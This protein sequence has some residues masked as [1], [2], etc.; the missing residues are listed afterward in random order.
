MEQSMLQLMEALAKTGKYCRN[1]TSDLH[2]N[3]I[4][5]ISRHGKKC[6]RWIDKRYPNECENYCRTPSND[7][8]NAGGPW[9]Y[10]HVIAEWDRCNIPICGDVDE[11]LSNPCQNGGTCTDRINGYKCTCRDNYVGVTCQYDIS[12][13]H[14]AACHNGG[15][16]KE[17]SNGTHFC[18]CPRRYTGESCEQGPAF[19]VPPQIILN[20]KITVPEGSSNSSIPCFAEGIPLPSIKWESIDKTSL[21]SNARQVVDFLIFENVTMADSGLYMCTAKNDIGTDFKVIHLIVKAKPPILH[22]GPVIHALSTVKVDYYTDAKLVCNVTGFPTPTVTWKHGN[23][24]LHTSGDIMVVQ[25]VTNTTAGYYTC[26][27][28][29]D[30]GTSQVNIFLEVTYDTPQ[31]VTHPRT[32]IVMVGQSHNFSCIA[33]GHPKPSITWSFKSFAQE[34]TTM[35]SHQLHQ[36]GQVLTIF[37]IKTLESGTLTCTAVNAFGDDRASVAVIFKNRMY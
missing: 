13:C 7:L 25:N 15:I 36:R 4:I 19:K 14:Y 2:Y 18:I 10:T 21:P 22:T 6:K 31:I 23:K 11:C 1:S 3:G 20:G 24:L 37:A 32:A 35:P 12:K 8:D 9:C 33:T 27:A 30:V 28:T 17:E 34:S 29:N 16:C 26:I 5:N